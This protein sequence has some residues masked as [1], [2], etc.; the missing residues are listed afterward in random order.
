MTGKLM[1]AATLAAV[2]AG[3][4]GPDRPD[5]AAERRALMEADRA[6]AAATAESGTSGWVSF[7]ADDGVQ[8]AAGAR[9][10]EGHGAIREAMDPFFSSSGRRLAWA[11]DTAVV[12][13]DATLGWT[14]GEYTITAPDS[15]GTERMTGR[16]RYVSIW[17][18]EP[19]GSW[20]VTMDVG[21][22]ADVP[23]SA[24]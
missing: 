20:K 4:G 16:G 2:L 11:P 18:K 12:S 24:E 8:I 15:S 13:G 9:R 1:A 17:R 6:F 22:P 7:F 5:P 3:C 19:D 10:L 14:T 23:L 21:S